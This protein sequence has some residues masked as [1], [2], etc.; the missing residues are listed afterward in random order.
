MFNRMAKKEIILTSVIGFCIATLLLMVILVIVSS[1]PITDSGKTIVLVLLGI[2]FFTI[3]YE[4]LITMEPKNPIAKPAINNPKT[5][6]QDLVKGSSD[7]HSILSHI[8]EAPKIT[9][10]IKYTAIT[11]HIKTINEFPYCL[12]FVGKGYDI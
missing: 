5:G 6:S 2:L 8:P 1:L 9:M 11:K 4:V 12:I 7:I 10:A 3:G